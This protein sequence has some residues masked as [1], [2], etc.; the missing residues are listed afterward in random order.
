MIC[1]FVKSE[2]RNAGVPNEPVMPINPE[3][4]PCLTGSEWVKY[5]DE[6]FRRRK[7]QVLEEARLGPVLVKAWNGGYG[8]A[9]EVMRDVRLIT[10]K[11]GIGVVVGMDEVLLDGGR[12][13]E[14]ALTVVKTWHG[15]WE[16]EIQMNR[17]IA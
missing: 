17:K 5:V 1:L 14:G 8:D 4:F 12:T 2:S 6:R 9:G 10:E 13:W 7:F 11:M 3:E 15:E 16:N